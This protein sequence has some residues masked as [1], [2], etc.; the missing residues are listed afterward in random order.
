MTNVMNSMQ[1]VRELVDAYDELEPDWDYA[2][3]WAQWCVVH[4]NGLQYWMEY[5]PN[6]QRGDTGWHTSGKQENY[7]EVA[8]PFGIDWRLC[9][10]ER[11]QGE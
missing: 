5:E 10:W 1:Q 3:E 7:D 4:A 2:P 9:K 11:P 6:W 8:L